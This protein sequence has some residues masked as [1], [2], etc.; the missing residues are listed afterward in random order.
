M[1][2]HDENVEALSYKCMWLW[3]ETDYVSSYDMWWCPQLH[4]DRPG[5]SNP[6]RCQLCQTL[7]GI[8]LTVDI[9]DSMKKILYLKHIIHTVVIMIHYHGQ[10]YISQYWPVSFSLN[11][12]LPPPWLLPFRLS[13]FDWCFIQ[14]DTR[15]GDSVSA[16]VF[17]PLIFWYQLVYVLC[18]CS[19]LPGVHH[20]KNQRVNE[21]LFF[22]KAIEGHGS[23]V[24]NDVFE[25]LCRSQKRS[26][27]CCIWHLHY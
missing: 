19:F 6:C 14:L 20:V 23:D 7:G 5:C 13:P 27:L 8:Y 4:L 17:C 3:G 9:E 12:S 11:L 1:S 18:E 25:W 22:A 21:L 26:F 10:C 24:G 2:G 15:V 16:I